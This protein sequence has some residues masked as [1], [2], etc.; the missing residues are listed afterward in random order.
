[1]ISEKLIHAWEV[2]STDLKIKIQTP[3]YLSNSNRFIR[4]DLI[5]ENFGTERGT[6]VMPMLKLHDIKIIKENGY[7]FSG[8]NYQAYS[9][10]NRRIFI[11]TLNEW[12]YFGDPSKT[13]DWYTGH[14]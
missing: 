3:F 11:D 5:I 9:N 6:I 8:L 12:G 2:A 13:P 4:F 14:I 1:M 10:Y 7:A